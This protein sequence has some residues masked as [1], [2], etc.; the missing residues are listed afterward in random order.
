MLIK[1]N[2]PVRYTV[3]EFRKIKGK[4]E[5]IAKYKILGAEVC[6][7]IKKLRLNRQSGKKRKLNKQEVKEE[8]GVLRTNLIEIKTKKKLGLD[9][10]NRKFTLM[11]SNVQSIKNKQ[12][13]I[14][15]LVEDSNADLA[16]LTETWLMD[17]DDIWVQG[18]EFHRHNYKIDEC[19]RKGRKGG[20][21]A[22][23]TKQN[24]KVKREEH[25]IAAELE[26]AKWKFTSSNSF[27]NILGVYRPP[28]SSIP[29]FL[30]IFM[31]LLVDIVTSNMNLVVLSN[32]NIH[33]NNID[34]PNAGIFLDTM[35][36]LGL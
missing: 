6:Y 7:R 32:F 22:L 21:F 30:D 25:R 35:T 34:D 1:K 26:Y 16:V 5:N 24:L 13:I 3:E 8:R 15:E 36:A 17:A 33:V 9:M 2:E 19:H 20:G 28:D 4:V 27:L 10:T 31:E 18:S 12:D 23:V 11:L 14:T 29:Q